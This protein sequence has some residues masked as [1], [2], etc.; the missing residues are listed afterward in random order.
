MDRVGAGDLAGHL[1]RGHGLAADG[2]RQASEELDQPGTAR[3]DDPGL[4][5]D[6]SCSGV[7]DGV[8]PVPH[9]PTS[10]SPSGS[11]SLARRSAS[12]ASSRMTDSIVPSTGRR[13]AR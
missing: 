11:G 10:S 3:V 5:Q 9:E 12:S 2:S 8:L 7:G 6:S 1:G 13:T 4:A